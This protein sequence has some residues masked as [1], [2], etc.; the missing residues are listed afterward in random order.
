MNFLE[1][2]SFR[3]KLKEFLEFQDK[4][5]TTEPYLRNCSFNILLDMDKKEVSNLHK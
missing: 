4:P 1:H 2:H 3:L 5:E